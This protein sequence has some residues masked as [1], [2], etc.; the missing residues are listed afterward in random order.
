LLSTFISSWS[1]QLGSQRRRKPS[2]LGLDVGFIC[3]DI[4]LAQMAT[5]KSI[6]R[7]RRPEYNV[8]T[9][10]WGRWKLADGPIKVM[11]GV[12]AMPIKGV[13][14]ETVPQ[15]EVIRRATGCINI[16]SGRL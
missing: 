8:I 15:G 5:R 7:R 1:R 6:W 14:W 2:D 11:P 12:Q 16:P 13:P 10:T 3:T 9:Y 4:D